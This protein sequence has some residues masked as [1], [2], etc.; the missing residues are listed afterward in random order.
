MQRREGYNFSATNTV[1]LRFHLP[2]S[3]LSPFVRLKHI[4]YFLPHALWLQDMSTSYSKCL[5]E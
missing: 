3:F 5:I 1:A 4:Q 2:G